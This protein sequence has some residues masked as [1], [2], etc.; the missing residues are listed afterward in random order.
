LIKKE[1]LLMRKQH[2][3]IPQEPREVPERREEPEIKQ[4]PDPK[5]PGTPQENPER[6]PVEIPPEDPAK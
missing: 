1:T 4:P 5:V 2:N 6:I 3:T